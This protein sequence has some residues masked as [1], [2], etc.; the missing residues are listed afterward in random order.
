MLGSIQAPV[1]FNSAD[2]FLTLLKD[3]E[4]KKKDESVAIDQVMFHSH[5]FT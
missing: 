3:L 1:D 2:G 4:G 5:M